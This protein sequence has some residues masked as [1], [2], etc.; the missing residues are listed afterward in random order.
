MSKH[1]R[2]NSICKISREMIDESSLKFKDINFVFDL[3][4]PSKDLVAKVIREP[5]VN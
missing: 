4:F 3:L 5:K 2:F 1:F